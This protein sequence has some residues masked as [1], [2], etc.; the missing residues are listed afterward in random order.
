MSQHL[1]GQV[2]GL[3]TSSFCPSGQCVEVGVAIGPSAKSS[4]SGLDCVKVALAARARLIVVSDSKQ[5][6]AGVPEPE[7]I[8]IGFELGAWELFIDTA[9]TGKYN[10]DQLLD[11]DD[12]KPLLGHQAQLG[13]LGDDVQLWCSGEPEVRQTYNFGEWRAFLL[14]V[15]AG[16]F[17]TATM[18]ARALVA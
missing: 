18:L 16:E 15:R 6:E 13:R 7:R 17:D 3:Y 12:V 14:G 11:V 2:T 4:F 5:A 1:I 8:R 10:Y 9:K